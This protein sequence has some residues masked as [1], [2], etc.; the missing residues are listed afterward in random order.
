[1]HSDHITSENLMS[2]NFVRTEK[3]RFLQSRTHSKLE[4]DDDFWC[5]VRTIR[6]HGPITG[7][8]STIRQIQQPKGDRH[9]SEK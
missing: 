7:L 4:L 9:E 8:R 3:A 5:A 2:T 6:R 1:M